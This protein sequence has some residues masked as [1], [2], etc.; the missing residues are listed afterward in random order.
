MS[1]YKLYVGEIS[2][3]RKEDWFCADDNPYAV[4]VGEELVK[5]HCSGGDWRI[6]DQ[7]LR[8]HVDVDWGSIAWQ[9]SKDEILSLFTACK[10]STE[11]LAALENG[12]DYAVVFIECAPS[13]YPL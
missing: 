1:F 4:C 8:S 7:L 6:A 2:P 11:A 12:K 3:E 13:D 9:G 5:A 10:L